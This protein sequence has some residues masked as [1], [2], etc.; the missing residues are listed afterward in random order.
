MCGDGVLG[1]TLS[2]VTV[3]PVIASAAVIVPI[4]LLLFDSGPPMVEE[5]LTLQAGGFSALIG[6]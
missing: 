6:G 3:A 4:T 1:A 2:R 5:L